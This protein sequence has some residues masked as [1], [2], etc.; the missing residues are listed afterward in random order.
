VLT[1]KVVDMVIFPAR[2]LLSFGHG[3]V[4]V[5]FNA[6]CSCNIGHEFAFL[7]FFD[8]LKLL[9]FMRKKVCDREESV[10]AFQ[11]FFERG[12]IGDIALLETDVGTVFEKVL[13]GGLAGIA[14]QCANLRRLKSNAGP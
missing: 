11:G 2:A 1:I 5:M 3:T 7:F 10:C 14:S 8:I 12:F 6:T 13:S 4:D 9:Q